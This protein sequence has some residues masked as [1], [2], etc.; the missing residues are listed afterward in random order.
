MLFL[1]LPNLH[2]KASKIISFVAILACLNALLIQVI[3]R[4]IIDVDLHHSQGGW[5]MLHRRFI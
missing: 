4:L 2:S 3:Q 5:L 1:K